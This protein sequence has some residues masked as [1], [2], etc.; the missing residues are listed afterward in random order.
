[1]FEAVCVLRSPDHSRI[2]TARRPHPSPRATW[3]VA[4]ARLRGDGA[5]R[6][7]SRMHAAAPSARSESGGSSP[8]PPRSEPCSQARA[9][10]RHDAPSPLPLWLCS[11][12]ESM[13]TRPTWSA[14][15]GA[16]PTVPVPLVLQSWASC[17]P[18][19]QVWWRVTSVQ[20]VLCLL[21]QWAACP[22][23]S[24]GCP[25]TP[26]GSVSPKASKRKS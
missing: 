22:E 2:Q 7:A 11:F 25:R 14:S 5:W 21:D 13:D 4:A 23:R 15:A 17:R 3:K 18:P 10:P 16:C 9:A 19:Q 20:F 6:R 24:R 1:M 26:R 8:A 12:L